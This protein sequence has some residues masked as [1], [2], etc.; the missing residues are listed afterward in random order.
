[1]ELVDYDYFSCNLVVLYFGSMIQQM[2]PLLLLLLVVPTYTIHSPFILV[3]KTIVDDRV[4]AGRN[5]VA[6]YEV[7]NAGQR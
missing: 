3:K 2:T 4:V 1:V 7:F 5:F 6:R